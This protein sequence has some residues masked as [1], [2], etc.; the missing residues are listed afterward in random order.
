MKWMVILLSCLL[1]LSFGEAEHA[2]AQW[3]MSSQT[4]MQTEPT[5]A[6]STE[7]ISL[8]TQMQETDLSETE[9]VEFSDAYLL[10]VHGLLVEKMI[11]LHII[12]VGISF[13]NRLV[14]IDVSSAEHIAPISNM[15]EQ[16]QI[17]PDC[18]EIVVTGEIVPCV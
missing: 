1:L 17:D 14:T 16:E 11:D 5:T 12:G 4:E 15:L 8:E 10:A 6:V 7:R 18:Y 2:V 9:L 13:T 3:E